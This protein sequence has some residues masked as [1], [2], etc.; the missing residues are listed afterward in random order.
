[1]AAGGDEYEFVPDIGRRVGLICGPRVRRIGKLDAKGDFRVEFELPGIGS[2][3]TYT[4][5]NGARPLKAYEYRSGRLILGTMMPDGNFVPEVGST[6]IDFKDFHYSPTAT[7]IWNLPG[8]FKK[9]EPAGAAKDV[10]K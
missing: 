10:K 2:E 5:L 8:Y 6:V 3:P 9:K 1:V 4:L 7:P